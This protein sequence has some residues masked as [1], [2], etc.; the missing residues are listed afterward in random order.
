MES[1]SITLADDAGALLA[2]PK[3][4]EAYLGEAAG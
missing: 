4:R 1:G 3:V 2:N